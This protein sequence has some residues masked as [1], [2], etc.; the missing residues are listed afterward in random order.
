MRAKKKKESAP[1][2][3]K[4]G[5]NW[6]VIEHKRNVHEIAI[7]YNNTQDSF[8]VLLVSDVHYDS[9]QCDREMFK[10]HIEYAQE[11]NAMVWCFGDL[12]DLMQGKYDKRANKSAVRPEYFVDR[13]IDAVC[14]DLAG[15]I[16]ETGLPWL[17]G[18]GNH[19]TS[20][21]RHLEVDPIQ[22]LAGR[23]HSENYPFWVGAYTGWVDMRFRRPDG[24]STRHHLT[25]Y[26]HGAGGNAPRTKGTLRVD[27]DM[28]QYPD[29]DLIC[30]G[31]DHQKWHIPQ[32]IRRY[33]G[34]T[35]AEVPQTVH[36]IQIGS[37]KSSGKKEMGYEVEKKFAEPRLGGWFLRFK[38]NVSLQGNY[39]DLSIMELQ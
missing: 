23:L 11:H 38:P 37:Y 31:H 25:H 14:D 36:H 17:L 5:E 20:I 4:Y 26:H 27:I 39:V 32:S 29:A 30:Q 21:I 13:Y 8:P 19:E 33:A 28:A 16:K 6:N 35:K 10:R 7:T 34:N 24:S 22:H 12:F 1:T 9:K 15:M 2:H 18:Y 3:F